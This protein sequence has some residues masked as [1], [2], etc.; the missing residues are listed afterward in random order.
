MIR[1]GI[2]ETL[3]RAPYGARG[4]KFALSRRQCVG[5]MESRP[6]WGA[7]IEIRHQELKDKLQVRRAPYGAR[8]LKW[9]LSRKQ[10]SNYLVAPRMGRVD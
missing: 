2:S 5:I 7:W 1:T 10:G 9:L 8:G 6:V 4:L 3:S